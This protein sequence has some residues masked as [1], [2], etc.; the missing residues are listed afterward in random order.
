M[1]ANEIYV[2]KANDLYAA[3]GHAMIQKKQLEEQIEDLEL[4]LK[5]LIIHNPLF[6]KVEQE[7]L[8]SLSKDSEEGDN[9]EL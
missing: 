2:A 7:T 5:G 1:N 8:A 4:K 3:L 9:G 6:Q